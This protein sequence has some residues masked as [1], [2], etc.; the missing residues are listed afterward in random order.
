[1][2]KATKTKQ[3]IFEI[4][5]RVGALAELSSLLSAARVNIKAICA[6]SMGKKGYFMLVTSNNTK[7]KRML[8]KLKI[9]ASSEDVIAVEMSNRAGQLK[10]TTAKVSEA[11]IDIKYMYGT[12]GTG[13]TAICVFK[14][15]NDNKAIKVIRQK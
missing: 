5:N 3:L 7:A 15:A 10:K 4:K 6:Y 12:A 9:K 8:A 1:M 2:A 11:G 13:K 14:T